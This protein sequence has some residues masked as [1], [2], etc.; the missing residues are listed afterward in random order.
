[1]SQKMFGGL[2]LAS[3]LPPLL[4]PPL[5]SHEHQQHQK[6]QHRRMKVSKKERRRLKV[7]KN[8]SHRTSKHVARAS[9]TTDNTTDEGHADALQQQVKRL[10]RE[11]QVLSNSVDERI[12]VLSKVL[13]SEFLQGSIIQSYLQKNSI[14]V[15]NKIANRIFNSIRKDAWKIWTEQTTNM[16][17]IALQAR[18][19]MFSQQGGIRRIKRIS[20]RRDDN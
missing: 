9:G 17:E 2:A 3:P 10:R 4:V 15:L 16:R 13:P 11:E 8:K 18:L 7:S 12:Q 1:M 14:T 20:T 19:S 6:N 5:S